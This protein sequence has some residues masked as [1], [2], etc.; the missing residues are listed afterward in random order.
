MV[1]AAWMEK[2]FAGDEGDEGDKASWV[3]GYG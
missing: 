1:S 2:P 3:S